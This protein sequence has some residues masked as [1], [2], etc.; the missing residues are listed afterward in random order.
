MTIKLK[1]KKKSVFEIEGSLSVL[2]NTAAKIYNMTAMLISINNPSFSFE[3][4]KLNYLEPKKENLWSFKILLQSTELVNI[5][6]KYVVRFYYNGDHQSVDYRLNK[7]GIYEFDLNLEQPQEQPQEQQQ[8][9]ENLLDVMNEPEK[10]Q[11][12]PETDNLLDL[13]F[14]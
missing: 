13:D 5:K 6:L 1:Y 4:E 2:N 7:E 11:P 8:E 14:L 9:N 10:T 12:K 3:P